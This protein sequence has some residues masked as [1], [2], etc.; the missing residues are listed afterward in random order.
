MSL[1]STVA[2]IKFC[3]LPMWCFLSSLTTCEVFVLSSFPGKWFQATPEFL[4]L[5]PELQSCSKLMMPQLH[6]H[7]HPEMHACERWKECD[8]TQPTHCHLSAH[9]YLHQTKF[10]SHIPWTRGKT[11]RNPPLQQ[12]TITA[13]SSCQVPFPHSLRWCLP[14]FSSN[15][16]TLYLVLLNRHFCHTFHGHP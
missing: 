4:A 6:L 1:C 8:P 14:L 13:P 10:L 11:R 3:E 12:L 16:I 9:P 5:T 15:R 7:L 2:E